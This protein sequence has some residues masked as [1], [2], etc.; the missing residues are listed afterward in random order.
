MTGDDCLCPSPLISSADSIDFGCWSSPDA[1]ERI[2]T[3]FAEKFG[4]SC[5]LQ[6]QFVAIDWKFA[7]RFALPILQRLN[8]IIESRDGHATFRTGNVGEL[9]RKR[10]VWIWAGAP[11]NAGMQVHFGPV[12]FNLKGG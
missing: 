10:G 9:L 7:P 6:D 5:F 12:A 3:G 1:L 8:P 4:D 2:V 11:K